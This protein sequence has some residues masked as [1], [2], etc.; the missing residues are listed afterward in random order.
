MKKSNV[1]PHEWWELVEVQ[2]KKEMYKNLDA[3]RKDEDMYER[4]FS[5][6]KKAFPNFIY[7]SLDSSEPSSPPEEAEGSKQSGAT[8]QQQEEERQDF[9]GGHDLQNKEVEEQVQ[10]KFLYKKQS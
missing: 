10:K 9:K 3:Q 7:K 1:E 5:T 6:F 8:C 2:F 4:H